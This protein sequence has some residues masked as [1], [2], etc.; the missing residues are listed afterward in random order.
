MLV[1][2]STAAAIDYLFVRDEVL[3]EALRTDPP[4]SSLQF[5][6]ALE[7]LSYSRVSGTRRT[8]T[9]YRTLA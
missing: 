6:E 2:R 5:L 1:C 4:F 9:G 3:L 7:R 8:R